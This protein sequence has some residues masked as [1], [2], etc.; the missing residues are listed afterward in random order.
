M[1]VLVI[2]FPEEA[3]ITL[4]PK[5]TEVTVS[6]GTITLDGKITATVDIVDPSLEG[7]YH[8]TPA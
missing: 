3:D 7:I 4:L 5:N 2:Q 6:D 1:K 8:I